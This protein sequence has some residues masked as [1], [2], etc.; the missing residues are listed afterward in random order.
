MISKIVTAA[1]WNIF[2]Q[3]FSC[4]RIGPQQ[5]DQRKRIWTLG[6]WLH[7]WALRKWDLTEGNRLW[8]LLLCSISYHLSFLFLSPISSPISFLPYILFS[9][10]LLTSLP[11]SLMTHMSNMAM[12]YPAL[13]HDLLTSSPKIWKPDGHRLKP[14]NKEPKQI[15]CPTNSFPPVFVTAMRTRLIQ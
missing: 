14:K 7:E 4:S 11:P 8:G 13:D 9:F 5:M 15:I 3:W 1:V 12:V 2:P 10:F 6:H